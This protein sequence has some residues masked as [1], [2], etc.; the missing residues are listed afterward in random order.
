[1]IKFKIKS[2]CYKVNTL[3]KQSLIETYC[4]KLTNRTGRASHKLD[5]VAKKHSSNPVYPKFCEGQSTDFYVREYERLNAYRFEGQC[6]GKPT[7]SL[8]LFKILSTNPQFTQDDTHMEE[9]NNDQDQTIY[10]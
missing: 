8:S 3:E 4:S 1:V 9:L 7:E 6:L 2:T 10:L 5:S